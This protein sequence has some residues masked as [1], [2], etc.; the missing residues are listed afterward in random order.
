[1]KGKWLVSVTK[2]SL[3]PMLGE[4]DDPPWRV[5][6]LV[7]SPFDIH[8]PG[9]SQLTDFVINFSTDSRVRSTSNTYYLEQR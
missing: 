6:S 1:M 8:Q 2:T 7:N 3:T 4:V 5:S 9:L